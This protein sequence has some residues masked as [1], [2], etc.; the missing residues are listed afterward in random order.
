[1][2][3]PGANGWVDSMQRWPWTGLVPYIGPP[4][5]SNIDFQ[6][7][8]TLWDWLQLRI[9]DIAE[10]KQV[11]MILQNYFDNWKSKLNRSKVQLCMMVKYIRNGMSANTQLF[12]DLRKKYHWVLST[13]RSKEL[14]DLLASPQAK[15][16]YPAELKAKEL[17]NR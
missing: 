11:S 17:E 14:D 16:I 15:V 5:N 10:N 2:L 9:F 8:K 6:R 4:H 13:H 12:I 1:M 3:D 7:G